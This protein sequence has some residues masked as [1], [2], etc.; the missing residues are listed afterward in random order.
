MKTRRWDFI[1]AHRAEFFHAAAAAVPGAGSV[2][3][4][5]YRR[6]ATEPA[7]VERQAEAAAAVVEIRAIH[8]EHR[9]A[10]GALR[11]HAELRSRGRTINHKRV[12]D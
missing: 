2:P 8:S 5:Q 1:S 9:S 3:L 12:T 7:R 11:V 6:L 10:Y 4:R